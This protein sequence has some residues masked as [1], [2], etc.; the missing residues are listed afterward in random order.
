MDFENIIYKKD[1]GIAWIIVNRPEKRNALNR[2]TR[3]EMISALEDTIA[4]TGVKVLII[5]GAGGKSFIAGSD[6]T[7]LSTFSPLEM[8]Q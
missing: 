2:A 6:L 1:E 4:D 7:E 8:E 5:S 3:L